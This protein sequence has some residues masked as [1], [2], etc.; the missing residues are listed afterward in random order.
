[1]KNEERKGE[2]E[3]IKKKQEKENKKSKISDEDK[4]RLADL[5][6]KNEKEMEIEREM[7]RKKK[8]KLKEENENI[9]EKPENLNNMVVNS[10]ID[11]RICYYQDELLL[12]MNYLKIT[13]V[14]IQNLESIMIS[15][16][17]MENFIKY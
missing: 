15:I 6:A 8:E 14:Q 5:A 7:K 17:K 16:W 9:K 12:M 4:K 1:M 11:L 2:E 13:L 10:T 3:R